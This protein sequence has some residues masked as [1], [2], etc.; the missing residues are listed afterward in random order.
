MV[1]EMFGKVVVVLI[2]VV[3]CVVDD[4]VGEVF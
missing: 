2:F 1:I 3:G 4:W